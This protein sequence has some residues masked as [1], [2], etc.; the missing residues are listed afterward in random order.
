M[1][2]I[3]GIHEKSWVKSTNFKKEQFLEFPKQLT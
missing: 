3:K 2:K 1:I